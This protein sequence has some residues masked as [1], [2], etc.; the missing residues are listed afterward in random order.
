MPGQQPDGTTDALL[1]LVNSSLARNPSSSMA[2]GRVNAY[3]PERWSEVTDTTDIARGVG[4]TPVRLI[5]FH[6]GAVG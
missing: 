6:A 3:N 4:N 2:D 5:V 1:G